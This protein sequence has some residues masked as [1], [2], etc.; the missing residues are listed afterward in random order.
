M[1]ERGGDCLHALAELVRILY[2]SETFWAYHLASLLL[3]K[4]SRHSKELPTA[5][6]S[7]KLIISC[8]T[9]DAFHFPSINFP[10]NTLLTFTR[11]NKA[12]SCIECSPLYHHLIRRLNLYD[13]LMKFW[14]YFGENSPLKRW[15]IINFVNRLFSLNLIAR[16]N[17]STRRFA[18]SW[19]EF[20]AQWIFK[21]LSLKRFP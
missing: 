7:R 15:W 19:F 3:S 9:F 12:S 13:L 14:F 2:D 5:S 16:H 4:N 1:R 17:F 18:P 6:Y 21:S 10:R 11:K 20:Q 8:E